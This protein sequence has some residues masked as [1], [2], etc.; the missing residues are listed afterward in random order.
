MLL[1][2]GSLAQRKP[3]TL[4]RAGDIPRAARGVPESPGLP[5]AEPYP[6]VIGRSKFDFLSEPRPGEL[7]QTGPPI[8]FRACSCSMIPR[9]PSRL[10]LALCL[11][12]SALSPACN[13]KDD[14]KLASDAGVEPEVPSVPTPPADGPKVAALADMTP[15]YERPAAD[16]TQL[17]YLRAGEML[18]RADKPFSVEKCSGGWYPVRPKGFVCVGDQATN[19]LLHPTLAVMKTLPRRDA[20]LPYSYVRATVPTK[21]YVW[22]RSRGAAVKEVGKLRAK[23]RVAVVG[24]WDAMDPESKMQHLAMTPGGQFVRVADFTEEEPSAFQGVEINEEHKLPLAF[25]VKHGVHQW[26]INKGE[27]IKLAEL[28]PLSTVALTGKFRTLGGE[29]FWAT[30]DERWVRHKDVTI[31]VKRHLLPDF[32][33]G[34]QKWIDISTVTGV[35][36]L[37][38]GKKPVFATLI[39]VGQDRLGDPATSAST[40]L[41]TFAITGKQLTTSKPGSKPFEDSFDVQDVPWVQEMSSGQML[42]GAF[43][44]NRFG[45]ENGPGNV[46]MSPA[47]AARVFGWTD[48]AL[49]EGWH[50]MTAGAKEPKKTIVVIRK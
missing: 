17:G 1:Y 3:T 50:G 46:Q 49:P 27:A 31:V 10:A 44:H 14:G 13:G 25:V 16:S 4:T 22:D 28:E 24:S 48:P 20:P 6:I 47:D 33:G 38:E 40:Q 39:S 8:R 19:N 23:S 34:E 12:A 11:V 2:H 7:Q 42:H 35:M 21:L 15:I 9:G 32:A 30:E 26:K 41:G 45:M 5:L 36:V 18:A 29:K 43:W 37:Y